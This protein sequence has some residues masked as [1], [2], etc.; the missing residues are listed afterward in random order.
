MALSKAMR[1]VVRVA[2]VPYSININFIEKIR[3]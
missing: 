1:A 2:F 3:R